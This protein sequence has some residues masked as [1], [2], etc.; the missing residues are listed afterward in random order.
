[1]GAPVDDALALID[2]AFLVQ[3][4]EDLD[5]GLVAALV[6]GKAQA[7]P[8]AGRAELFKLRHDAAA[9]LLLPLPG[10]HKKLIAAERLLRGALLTQLFNDLGLGGDRRMVGAGQPERRIALHPPGAND[11]ILQRF[12]ERMP[13][14]ELTRDVGRRDNDGIG[15]LGRIDNGVKI[16]A[17]F[18]L[19]VYLVF[20]G[21]WFVN[22]FELHGLPPLSDIS[23][24]TIITVC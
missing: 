7:V 9:V 15:P 12:V 8:I 1:M 16:M 20:N 18:P 10:A 17:V 22:F 5:D 2:G 14:V 3:A 6:H 21:R 24:P 13:H 23:L 19:F 11:D 4:A